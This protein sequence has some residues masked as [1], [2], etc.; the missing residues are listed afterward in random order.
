MATTRDVNVRG[1]ASPNGLAP[2]DP[3]AVDGCAAES[4]A[5]GGQ[6]RT[7]PDYLDSIRL[8][9]CV[10][11]MAELPPRCVDLVITDPPFAIDFKAART[12]YN[13]TGSRVI[14]G[15]SEIEE[16]DYQAFTNA[17]LSQAA[18]VLKDSG[19]MYIFSGWNHLKDLLIAIDSRGLTTVN[20]VI[21][22]YQFGVVTTR[23][24]VTSHYHCL[25]VCKDDAAR[26]FRPY[27]RFDKDAK[28]GLSGS[29][30]YKDKEDVWEIKREYWHGDLKT[31]TKLPAEIIRKMLAYSSDEGDVV[32][33][34]F[35]GS[36]QV[37]VVS[38]MEG[39]RYIGFEIAPEYYDFALDRLESGRY[40]I[41][42]QSAGNA[43]REQAALL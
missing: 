19:S 7:E 22:K 43:D 30:H 24:Y 6:L 4:A 20:H 40:R 28:N 10:T 3:A 41:K 14:D 36:G 25:Y 35:L 9:D 32:L 34:P 37:A 12:N 29:A 31:P 1:A 27:A 15:Y 21:W 8:G 39:R 16:N 5:A 33:D 2:S 38:K 26:K 17:W 18:R 11:L 23:K 13:R 42:E